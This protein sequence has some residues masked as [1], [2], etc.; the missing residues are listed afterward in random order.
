MAQTNQQK[1]PPMT[2]ERKWKLLVLY[3]KDKDKALAQRMRQDDPTLGSPVG[4]GAAEHR[5][6]AKFSLLGQILDRVEQLETGREF[7]ND[8]PHAQA[9][10]VDEPY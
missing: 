8:S 1:Q 10:P 7:I 5:L 3:L 9:G 2:P 4:T 6:L